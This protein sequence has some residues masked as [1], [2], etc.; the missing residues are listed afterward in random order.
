MNNKVR[1]KTRYPEKVSNHSSGTGN[2][3]IPKMSSEKIPTYP[4]WLIQWNAISLIPVQCGRRN[5]NLP[6][7]GMSAATW[8]RTVEARVSESVNELNEAKFP[9]LH[10]RKEGWPRDQ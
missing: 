6:L 7:T 9:S 4:C 8:P 5:I 1:L 2:P 10:Y 3:T